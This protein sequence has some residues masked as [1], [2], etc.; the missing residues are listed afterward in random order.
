[1]W[2]GR[3]HLA[4]LRMEAVEEA[5][6]VGQDAALGVAARSGSALG[7]FADRPVLQG[8]GVA[9]LDHLRWVEA[10]TGNGL[11]CEQ[12]VARDARLGGTPGLQQK[13]GDGVGVVVE[14]GWE[15]A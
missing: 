7:A 15:A 8:E 4:V 1:M 5:V 2:V 11:G 9:E 10:W 3:E 13:R 12:V 14:S 6:G